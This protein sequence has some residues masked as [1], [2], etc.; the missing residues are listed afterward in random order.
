MLKSPF[1]FKWQESKTH[2]LM[3]SKFLTPKTVGD[4]LQS[5]AWQQILGEPPGK[6]VERFVKEGAVG[7][8]SLPAKLD[9]KYKVADLK[10]MANER[11]LTTS[12]R[13]AGLIERLIQSSAQE[14][15]AFVKEVNVLLCTEQGRTIAERYLEDEKAR[16][17]KAEGDTLTWLRQSKFREASKIAAVFRSQQVFPQG[18]S[19]G[20]DS[21]NPEHDIAIL[22]VI[23]NEIPKAIGP[24]DSSLLG[25]LRIAAGMGY[26]WGL[27]AQQRFMQNVVSQGVNSNRAINL[28]ISYAHYRVAVADYRRNGGI[29]RVEIRTVNDSYVCDAC[30]KLASKTYRLDLVPELPYENCTCEDGCRC[31]VLPVI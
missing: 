15:Q 5:D 12:G 6:A 26:L 29:K 9:Y 24:I 30:R 19:I 22:A 11:G 10:R 3:L 28:L 31:W 2:L 4:F 21:Y 20:G 18:I 1:G 7:Q 14:M 23:F 13:K 17:D 27:K 25:Q 8:A 16:Q